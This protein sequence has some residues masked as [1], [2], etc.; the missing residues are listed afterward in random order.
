MSKR[1]KGFTLIEL[2]VVISII[3]LLLG[4][5]LPTLGEAKRRARMLQDV[6]N[7]STHGKA[8]GIYSAENRG[9]MPNITEGGGT[10]E[11]GGPRGM[12]KGTFANRD[13]GDAG[14]PTPSGNS[15][16]AYNGF[17]FAS[18]GLNYDDV[19]RFPNIAFGD[20][21]VDGE[22]FDLLND[23]FASPGANI[24]ENWQIIKEGTNPDLMFPEAFKGLGTG[25]VQRDWF[26]DS[27]YGGRN[28]PDDNLMWALQGSYRYTFTA[29]YGTL[30]GQVVINTGQIP[31]NF[32]IPTMGGTGAG[33]IAQDA[34]QSSQLSYSTWRGYVQQADFARPSGKVAFWQF[35]PINTGRAE[36]YYQPFAEVAVATVDGSARLVKTFDVMPDGTQA[37]ESSENGSSAWG[38]QARYGG[39]WNNQ[40]QG[41]TS[42]GPNP[43]PFAWFIHTTFGPRGIDLSGGDS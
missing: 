30:S 42:L 26:N 25:G 24:G 28:A 8:I 27:I 32:W 16:S 15:P 36:F 12:P 37:S 39:T 34:W 43:K 20:Y 33:E 22:G 6:A 38:T 5:L 2:L 3:A 9:R 41:I 19:W 40:G 7:L 13:G 31:T 10:L 14:G 23:V 29:L 11:T 18:G 4:I 1:I 17:A 35:V 21:M